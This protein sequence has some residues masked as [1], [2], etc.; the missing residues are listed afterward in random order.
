MLETDCIIPRHVPIPHDGVYTL[1]G[2]S[3]AVEALQRQGL[4]DWQIR[5]KLRIG[6]E[7][8]RDAV[9]EINKK[10]A[11]KEAAEEEALEK[12]KRAALTAEQ[13][14]EIYTRYKQGGTTADEIAKVFGCCSSTVWNIIG[15]KRREET[16]GR[17]SQI[18]PE[19]DAAVNQMI[20][21]SKA[22]VIPAPAPAHQAAVPSAV[23]CAVR[24]AIV[25]KECAVCEMLGK[26]RMMQQQVEQIRTETAQLR[27]WV[28][29]V[30]G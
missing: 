27:T 16:T 29:E 12:K 9:Y 18:N 19:F 10:N 4:Q 1:Y 28:E 8:Y 20:E 14:E 24:A 5:C 25:E 15:E 30:G 23:I 11:A 22:E 2:N 13:K 17:K 26:I 21:E 7:A 6:P 3:R